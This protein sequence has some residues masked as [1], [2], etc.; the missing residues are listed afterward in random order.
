MIKPI[1]MGISDS[2]NSSDE[3]EDG[4]PPT[5]SMRSRASKSYAKGASRG[6]GGG[7]R[8][9]SRSRERQSR[10]SDTRQDECERGIAM[11]AAASNQN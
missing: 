9:S 2:D 8:R 7:M 1:A 4:G 5:R 3:G 10:V 6:R 11:S